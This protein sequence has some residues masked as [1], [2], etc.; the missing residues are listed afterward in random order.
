MRCCVQESIPSALHADLE[1]WTG[2]IACAL[3]EETY[4]ELLHA[5][6]FTQVEFKVTRRYSIPD[7]AESGACTS[8]TTLTEAEVGAFKGK[9]VSAFIHACK[10]H[11]A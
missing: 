3:E 9:F 4:R 5:A 8:L 2:C 11:D 6:G 7:L 10:P 1:A